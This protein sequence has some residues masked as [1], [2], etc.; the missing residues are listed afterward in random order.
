KVKTITDTNKDSAKEKFDNKKTGESSTK[1]FEDGGA[2]VTIRKY[3]EGEKHCTKVGNHS[4]FIP[5]NAFRVDHFPEP[6][7]DTLL[8]D[9]VKVLGS[10][11]V[12]LKI[13]SVSK[14]RPKYFPETFLE[15]PKSCSS[16]TGR[17]IFS[18]PIWGTETQHCPCRQCAQS[19]RPCMKW[20]EIK[21]VT[22]AHVVFDVT[23]AECTTCVLDYD[24]NDCH[25]TVKLSFLNNE[26]IDV[27]NDRSTIVFVTHD[28]QM[29]YRLMNKIYE[30]KG[31]H[32][33]AY[34]KYQNSLS[35]FNIDQQ[36]DQ[37]ERHNAC[38]S[39]DKKTEKLQ[40]EDLAI[41]ISHPH[42][43]SKQVSIGTS[44][45]IVCKKDI[46]KGRVYTYYE[47]VLTSCGGSS[48]APVYILGK[49]EVWTNHPHKGSNVHNEGVSGI[50]YE[51]M[52]KKIKK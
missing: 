12:M 24:S 46:D 26:I 13:S 40:T 50:E 42:G 20:G 22:A 27:R 10:L 21:V 23:E 14:R 28:I 17:I 11:V 25:E 6:Y 30:Y 3:F 7:R 48:G 52:R 36:N 45:K 44:K 51:P 34:A 38:E 19:S 41:L 47:Y 9:L 16:G 15:Y 37:P 4:S 32:D 18:K 8:V 5:Y 43:W 31:L 39:N 35:T 29:A 2:A 1:R 33:Q 49:E